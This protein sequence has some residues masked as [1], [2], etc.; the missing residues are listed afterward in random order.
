MQQREKKKRKRNLVVGTRN[1]LC[2]WEV[3]QLNCKKITRREQNVV[4]YGSRVGE[5]ECDGL[6]LCCLLG[7]TT[8]SSTSVN[9]QV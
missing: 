4:S 1:R 8:A 5:S 7:D 6:E 3:G 2:L 9:L